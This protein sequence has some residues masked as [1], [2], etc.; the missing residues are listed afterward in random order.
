MSLK[1]AEAALKQ[2]VDFSITPRLPS[3]MRE[4]A[5]DAGQQLRLDR[6]ADRFDA[7]KLNRRKNLADCTFAPTATY[8]LPSL[9]EDKI[10]TEFSASLAPQEKDKQNISLVF[11]FA[12]DGGVDV[13]INIL[14]KKQNYLLRQL[15][16][17]NDQIQQFKRAQEGEFVKLP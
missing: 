16:I 6:V 8:K 12:S 4:A 14:K 3:K 7:L 17:S 10:V 13:E 15:K 11:T 5:K 1:N 2:I 9:K